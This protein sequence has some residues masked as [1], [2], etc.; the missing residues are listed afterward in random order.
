MRGKRTLRACLV[1]AFFAGLIGLFDA[2]VAAAATA[3]WD[4]GGG[5]GLWSNPL[6]WSGDMLPAPDDDIVIVGNVGDVHLDIDVTLTGTLTVGRF[7]GGENATL[8]VD[9]GRTLTLANPQ[10]F[11]QLTWSIN[12][13]GRLVNRGTVR[14][15]SAEMRLSGGRLQN[16]AVGLLEIHD[17]LQMTHGEIVNDGLVR[18]IGGGLRPSGGH[19][20]NNGAI[21]LDQGVIAFRG[22]AANGDSF[23]NPG[24]ISG[25]G[26]FDAGD[27]FSP[28]LFR[29]PLNNTGTIDLQPFPGQP[30][31]IVN[32]T[33]ISNAGTITAAIRVETCN[34]VIRNTGTLAGVVFADCRVWIGGFTP[35]VW[36]NPKN[37]SADQPPVSGEFISI[38]I[39]DPPSESRLDVPFVANGFI[40]VRAG[41]RLVVDTG[42]V[43]DARGTVQVF[44]MLDVQSAMLLGGFLLNIGNATT[45]VLAGGSLTNSGTIE[46]QFAGRL[47]NDG[48]LENGGSIINNALGGAGTLRNTGTLRNHA[49]IRNVGL[50]DNTGVIDNTDGLIRNDC[51]GTIVS[52]G[53]I[54]GNPIVQACARWDGEGG[55]GLWSNPLNWSGDT[56]PLT[57]SDVII[58]GN[59]GDVHL[60]ID[61]T[62]V[63]TL[64]VGRF[65]FNETA[66]L[67][68]DPGRTL[69]L[70]NPDFF[71]QLTYS[72]NLGGAL[73]NRG[74][75][76]LQ[77]SEMRLS[78]GRLRN[79][80]GG[81]LE[82][83]SVLQMTQ[84][85]IVNDST[86]HVV[87]GVLQPSGGNTVNNGAIVL[88]E[89]V[90][91]FR[92]QLGE[93]F[94]NFGAI[95]GVGR[96]DLGDAFSP[97]FFRGPFNNSGTVDLVH[98]TGQV[99]NNQ[100]F[101]DPRAIINTT[102][103]NNFNAIRV[104]SAIDNARGVI[105]NGCGAILTVSGIPFISPNVTQA[106]CDTTPPSIVGTFTPAPNAAGWNN[107]NVVV[108]FTCFDSGAGLAPGSPPADTTLSTEGAGQSETG[109]CT[110]LAGN[111]A[112]AVVSGIN[113]DK[114][115]PS[116]MG[117]RTPAPNAFGWN[118]GGVTVS[119]LCSDGLSGL[120][121]GSPP[122]PTVVATD[123]FNQSVTGTC[124]DVAD[125]TAAAT[126]TGINVDA[127]PPSVTGTPDR[128]PD[129]GVWYNHALTV[130]WQGADAL[131]G[132]QGCSLPSTYSGPDSAGVSLTG[133]CTD[134]ANNEGSGVFLVRFDATR[135]V[136]TIT[137]PAPGA[138]YLQGSNVAAAYG[139]S[140]NLSGVAECAGPVAS[141]AAIDTA[142]AGP[143]VFVVNA[144]DEA[145]NTASTVSAYTVAARFTFSGFLPPVDNVPAVNVENAGRVVP[146][147]W[148]LTDAGGAPVSALTS[149]G[150]LTSSA[151][152]CD[153]GPEM[154]VEQS[155]T[156][157]GDTTV[158]FDGDHFIF[159]WKTSAAWRGCRLLSL[160]LSDGSVHQAKFRFR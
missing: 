65:S 159:N 72:I 64:S 21:V 97:M 5:D 98:L 81:L 129:R 127:T 66:T 22:Q 148:R 7:V 20:V 88:E 47:V 55:D 32:R 17:T 107:T 108:H 99:V 86:V 31:A 90:V 45:H 60:D 152:A 34:G 91:R 41:A 94:D 30:F 75:V 38:E 140:D 123:G 12:L 143:K 144:R 78:G 132:I 136:A 125:N 4:G 52:A 46:N 146:I 49:T 40:T 15:Q 114:T 155:A 79:D 116:I 58:E 73:V 111:T 62:L 1:V 106:A 8:I 36:S 53:T 109:M 92:A 101:E 157:A 124:R 103:I 82:I 120:A 28:T 93:S 139:C 117:S 112:S 29:A 16:E 63:G 56:L 77:S 3:T 141:G 96:L 84:G 51:L 130:F 70:A 134:R 131:S 50:F 135:P 126:V 26:R 74:T 39:G 158:R 150:S 145:G 57:D 118:N 18:V 89:G 153:G 104:A 115:P 149:F 25:V 43:L 23:D 76:D 102:V 10:P 151:V 69:T 24:T 138:V 147:K 19:T 33:V 71:R 85:E 156:S 48:F 37:W 35:P 61:F 122:A 6:N 110:D 95:S 80:T 2:P 154:L 27:V 160:Q 121:P 113:I 128:A 67:I 59:V 13:G 11:L 119:F 100:L 68:V 83:H 54:L 87:G 137:S 133:T 105:N 142:T 42:G 44:G 14:V 9:A